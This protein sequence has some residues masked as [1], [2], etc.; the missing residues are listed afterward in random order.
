MKKYKIAF[1]LTHPIQY[2]SPF[3]REIAKH[4]QI[5]LTVYYCSD[6]SI[7][8]MKDVGFG[9][10]IK[11]DIPLLEGYKYRTL[12]NHSPKPS[13]FAGFFGLI[14]TGIINELKEERYD[15]LIVHGW[16]Y[17]TNIVAI[18][19]TK[20]FGVKVFIRGENPLNQELGKPRYKILIKKVIF[21]RLLFRIIDNFLY[22]GQQN[23]EFYEFYGVPESKLSFVPYAVE[24]ERFIRGYEEYKNRKGE[25]KKEIGIS[26]YKVVILFSGKLIVKKRP[27]DLLMAYERLQS[28]NKALVYIGDGYLRENLEEYT[29]KR[30]L[31]DVYFFGFKNQTELPKYYV[32]SDIFVL[33]STIGETW[34]L[35][36]NEAMCFHLPIIVSDMV[37]CGKDLVKHG[38]NGYIYP[39]GNI[40][41]LADCLLKLLQKPELR[42]RMGKCSLEIISE[43]S[44]KEDI[45]G[46]LSALEYVRKHLQLNLG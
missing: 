41:K 45:E 18:I 28:E 42:E 30:N 44:F 3:F 32:A 34:G 1:L 31:K 7:K 33:P 35:V 16:N 5:D 15:A 23:K 40:Q 27:M 36:V 39:V 12:K 37:G 14:N 20:L 17:F 38:E 22:V 19:T 26:P 11:W 9:K 2:F 43:W 13:I 6:E 24:N 25:I 8:G 21:K 46:I 10:E 29:K 4:P